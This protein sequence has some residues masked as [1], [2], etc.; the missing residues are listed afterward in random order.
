MT[1]INHKH[2]NCHKTIIFDPSNYLK[3]GGELNKYVQIWK[4]VRITRNQ[5]L[6]YFVLHDSLLAD[7]LKSKA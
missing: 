7:I 4:E 5:F 3:L 1:Y 6:D 2:L